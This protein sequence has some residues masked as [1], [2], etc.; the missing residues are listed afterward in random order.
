MGFIMRQSSRVLPMALLLVM[1]PAWLAGPVARAQVPQE[2][3]P[4]QGRVW[5]VLIGV[6]KYHRA[7]HLRYTLNDVRE[8]AKTLR[9]RGGVQAEQMLELTDDAPNARF[10]PLR[11]S[12]MAELPEFLARPAPARGPADRLLQRPRLPG[13]AGP[14]LP[15]AA[16]L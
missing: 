13:Q 14:A 11:A 8:L 16:G 6:E 4:S 7:N 3:V 12:L 10:Q 2:P 5:A 9:T 1:V 15:R